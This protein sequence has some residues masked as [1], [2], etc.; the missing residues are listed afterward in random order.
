M[1][2]DRGREEGEGSSIAY[3]KV[4]VGVVENRVVFVEGIER[5]TVEVAY[6][7]DGQG[8]IERGNFRGEGC[9]GARSIVGRTVEVTDRERGERMENR[10]PE[11][12]GGGGGVEVNKGD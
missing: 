4:N 9:E 8:G 10:K 12:A 6:D 1:I 2:R 5:V 11:G 7:K 3:E